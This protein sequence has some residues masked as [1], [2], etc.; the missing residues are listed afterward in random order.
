MLSSDRFFFRYSKFRKVPWLETR[1]P[2][3]WYPQSLMCCVTG[4]AWP[5]R[6]VSKCCLPNRTLVPVNLTRCFPEHC[7]ELA[8]VRCLPLFAICYILENWQIVFCELVQIQFWE[9]LV[10]PRW[11]LCVLSVDTQQARDDVEMSCIKILNCGL[12][13]DAWHVN[14]N[15]QGTGSTRLLKISFQERLKRIWH[16][17]HKID[18]GLFTNRQRIRF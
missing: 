1:R 15:I 3:A 6:I 5:I 8:P 2:V 4:W 17:Y 14:L 13:S 10:E 7:I 18:H 9:A 16:Q 12:Y 11:R